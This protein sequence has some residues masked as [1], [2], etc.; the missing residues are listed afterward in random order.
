MKSSDLFLTLLIFIIFISLLVV[1]VIVARRNEIKENWPKYRCNPTI[2]PFAG[3][4]GQDPTTNFI[5]CVQNTQTN[6]MSHLLQPIFYLISNLGEMVA[7]ITKSLQAVRGFLNYFRNMTS[8][9]VFN[10]FG[11]FMNIL[12]ELQKIMIAMRDT[13]GKI[14]GLMTVQIYLLEGIFLTAKSVWNGPIGGS[15]RALTGCFDESTEFIL[16][17]QEI[18]LIKD[19]KIGDVLQ[20]GSVVTGCINLI[21]HEK[22]PFYKVFSEKLNKNLYI[23]GSH[24]IK[25]PSTEKF[26]PIAE[27]SKAINTNT[28]KPIIYNLMTD[29]H[30]ITFGEYTLKD[31][32]D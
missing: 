11:V 29:D 16:Q 18:K 19:I 30:L 31:W 4:F 13:M 8:G 17:N 27:Y 3:Q 21:G 25:D 32:E 20:N 1:N 24:M 10:I 14:G 26:I 22:N 6:Y 2:M 9:L 5:Y 28:H 7:N 15:V 23:T 12:V